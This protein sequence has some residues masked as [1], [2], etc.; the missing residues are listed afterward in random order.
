MIVQAYNDGKVTIFRGAK[1]LCTFIISP[2]LKPLVDSHLQLLR[3]KR[4][5]KW[6]DASWGS[7]ADIRFGHITQN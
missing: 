7:E 5:T 6:H 4:R 3:L 2:P 1:C